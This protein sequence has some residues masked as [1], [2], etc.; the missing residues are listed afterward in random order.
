MESGESWNITSHVSTNNA[1]LVLKHTTFTKNIQLIYIFILFNTTMAT[2]NV[3]MWFS[4]VALLKTSFFVY[5]MMTMDLVT[6]KRHCFSYNSFPIIIAI[7]IV[8][9][10][11]VI[12]WNQIKYNV[13]IVTIAPNIQYAFI[14]KLS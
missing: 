5:G 12:K 7:V 14:K 4:C 13:T 9:V 8:V 2:Q 11:V 1:A 3:Y 6:L 10:V